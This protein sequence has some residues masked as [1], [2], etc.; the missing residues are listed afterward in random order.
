MSEAGK[1]LL[2]PHKLLIIVQYSG[3][4]T[5]FIKSPAPPCLGSQGF[6][7]STSVIWGWARGSLEKTPCSLRHLKWD[8]LPKDLTTGSS[9]P[10]FSAT[11]SLLH[12]KETINSR[13]YPT[14]LA[15]SPG[16]VSPGGFPLASISK[17]TPVYQAWGFSTQTRLRLSFC[18]IKKGK[19]YN[20]KSSWHC[21]LMPLSY[22][23]P[24]LLL[25]CKDWFQYCNKI[26]HLKFYSSPLTFFLS[27]SPTYYIISLTSPA[28]H[29]SDIKL[30][31]SPPFTFPFF[32]SFSEP[33]AVT[34]A[35]E[36]LSQ[37]NKVLHTIPEQPEQFFKTSVPNTTAS[38]TRAHTQPRL[39]PSLDST[40]YIYLKNDF[41]LSA[42]TVWKQPCF[43]NFQKLCSSFYLVVHSAWTARL[44][45]RIRQ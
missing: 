34:C 40:Q 2:R 25:N 21:W 3:P 43:Q 10:A 9:A 36:Q 22:S 7:G 28:W 24:V 12:L 39:I 38:H 14:A 23:M 37:S 31:A 16:A 8:P 44:L 4:Q 41:F 15:P 18:N 11:F 19:K 29:C 1:S 27:L 42:C 32:P 45:L 17:H 30:E 5:R 35:I 20:H 33:L 13:K 26:P 6:F